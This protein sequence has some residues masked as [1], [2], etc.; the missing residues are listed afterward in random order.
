MR[1]PRHHGAAGPVPPDGA[2]ERFWLTAGAGAAGEPA[3]GLSSGEAAR[4]LA[5][6]GPNRIAEPARRGLPGRI[7]RRMADPLVLI[8]IA[9]ALVSGLTGDLAS[10]MIIIFIVAFSVGLD[11]FQEHGAEQAAE[12]LRR[13]IAL[14]VRVRRDAREITVPA[15][16]VVRGDL[17]RLLPGNLVPADGVVVGSSAARVDE[18]ILTGEPYPVEKRPGPSNAATMAEAWDA[19]FAGT[20]LISGEAT[21]RVVATGRRTCLGTISADL[22]ERQPPAAFER[23]LRRLGMLILR[24]TLALVLFVLLVQLVFHRPP[25]ESF[26]FAAALAVGL[27][28]ELLPMVTTV[29]LS[30]GAVRMARR[31]VIVKRLAAIHDLGAMNVLCT[32]KTG[33]LTE[34]RI[35]LT[36]AVGPD[37]NPDPHLL[38]LAAVNSHF[39][40]GAG[41]PL[42]AAIIAAAP[43]PGEGWRRRAD[44]PFDFERRRSAVLV[45]RAGERRLIVKGAPE[46]VLAL[47]DAVAD[48]DGGVVLM[49]LERR[50]AL[51]ALHAARA[52]EGERMLAIAWRAVAEARDEV[53]PADEQGLVFAGFCAF[54]DPPKPS[55]AAAITRLRR[56]GV[57]V[58]IISGDAAAVVGHLVGALGLRESA[59]VTGEELAGLSEAALRVKVRRADYFARISPDQKMQ[60]IRALSQSGHTV[61]FMG[62]GINDAPA[63]KAADAGLSVDSA[64]DVAREAADLILLDNDLSV[65]ADG[66]LEGRRTYANIMKY[67]RMGTSSNFGNMLSMALASLVVP[68]LPMTAVQILL[69]NLLYDLSQTGIPFDAVDEAELAR[70]HDWSMAAIK[71]YTAFMGPLSS[72]F[73]VMTFAALLLVFR[74]AP[75]EFRAAWFLESMLTQLLVIFV[76][77]TNCAPWRSRPAKPLVATVVLAGGAALLAVLGPWHELFG[78]AALP[79]QL[80]GFVMALA[81]LYLCAAQ[82]IKRWAVHPLKRLAQP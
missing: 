69:N 27:T 75:G 70:P 52:G 47:C 65:I 74:A 21:M 18:A 12:A 63:I 38:E 31:K 39:E 9:A 11:V 10:L 42:D 16:A 6:D 51:E 4:R 5:S 54:R 72:A 58:K 66:V 81:M 29:T 62:D 24:L 44:L 8:L 73:D 67:V 82:V 57:H 45:E 60:I 14:T 59:V 77:R 56:L 30:R 1:A 28:P 33:T 50:A 3:T 49:D 71:R 48:G 78:F 79:W 20:A 80:L 43:A 2:T 23:G 7:I 25:L 68:F 40:T 26:M 76:I 17:V 19:L 34:A 53:T 32:D 41:N 35:A 15:E 64:T 36:A 13:S 37:G 22:A 55:A 46:A 61:G